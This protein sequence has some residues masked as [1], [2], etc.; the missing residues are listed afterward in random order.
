MSK[1]APV[2]TTKPTATTPNE[3]EAVASTIESVVP[4][5]SEVPP[6]P[7]DTSPEAN[8]ID[9]TFEN[10]IAAGQKLISEGKTK[11]EAAMAIYFVL[12]NES[13]ERIVEAFI[14]GANLTPKGALTYWYNCRRKVKKQR[15]IT[16]AK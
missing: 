10:A 4:E 1:K 8:L 12:E 9:Q 14:K 15:M 2:K 6:E 7:T 16:A 5:V 11:V 3:P 13:Q